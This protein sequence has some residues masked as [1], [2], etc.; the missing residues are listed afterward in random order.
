MLGQLAVPPR[1]RALLHE[2]LLPRL[3]AVD[4]PVLV[5]PDEHADWVHRRA[6]R[7]RDALLRAGYP[8]HGDPDSLLP[9]GRSGVA[10]PSDAGVLA[11]AM[12]LLLEKG[13]S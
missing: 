8:V 7:M 4:G 3:A 13:G 11:L 1:R 9:V 2:T 5:V 6:V 12:R 10:E